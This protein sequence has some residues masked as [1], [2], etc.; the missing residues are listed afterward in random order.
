MTM[1]ECSF[2]TI[3]FWFVS[4]RSGGGFPFSW[5][6]EQSKTDTASPRRPRSAY[7]RRTVAVSRKLVFTS[8]IGGW[9]RGRPDRFEINS[10]VSAR[11]ARVNPVRTNVVLV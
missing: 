7:D 6:A 5:Q 3:R 2:G 4:Y 11:K 1:S 10:V 8:G 9:R